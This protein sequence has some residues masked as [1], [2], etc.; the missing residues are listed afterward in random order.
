ME[1]TSPEVVN[2]AI[3]SCIWYEY[4]DGVIV[5]MNSDLLY[6]CMKTVRGTILLINACCDQAFLFNFSILSYKEFDDFQPRSQQNQ[7]HL[8]QKKNSKISSIFL[9]KNFLRTQK[10]QSHL[11]Q[12]T[13]KIQY[14]PNSFGE[15]VT[16]FVGKKITGTCDMGSLCLIFNQF[17]VM[18]ALTGSCQ[19]IMEHDF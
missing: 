9:S 11:H 13:K 10:K 1:I 16:K 2:T 17:P 12:K 5:E 3:Q 4:Q 7:S 6:H 18:K 19:C 8:Y 14:F 15:E